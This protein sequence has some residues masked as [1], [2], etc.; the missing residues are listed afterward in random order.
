M[1][2]NPKDSILFPGHRCLQ[3]ESRIILSPHK[4]KSTYKAGYATIVVRSSFSGGKHLPDLL[5]NIAVQKINE[6]HHPFNQRESA[7]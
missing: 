7:V 1:L 5:Y 6:Q 3:E 4:V 2:V